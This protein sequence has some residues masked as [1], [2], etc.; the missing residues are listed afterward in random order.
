MESTACLPSYLNSKTQTQTNEQRPENRRQAFKDGRVRPRLL[1]LVLSL[2]SKAGVD[3]LG[4]CDLVWKR[5]NSSLPG[6]LWS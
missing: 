2:E 6:L 1:C 5:L 4:Y 3:L